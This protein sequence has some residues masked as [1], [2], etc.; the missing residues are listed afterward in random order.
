MA[1]SLDAVAFGGMPEAGI[2]D[3]VEAPGQDVLEESADEFGSGDPAGARPAGLAVP[4][5]EGDG[6]VVDGE[7]APIGD[8][9]AEDVSGEVVED[10][11]LAGR[12]GG[13]MDDPGLVPDLVGEIEAGEALQD[14][15]AEAPAHRRGEGFG[16]DQKGA[17]GGVPDGAVVGE[18]AAGD[19]AVNVGVQVEPLAPGVQD[20]EDADGAADEGGIAGDGDD[21]VAGRVDGRGGQARVKPL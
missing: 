15:G 12:P 17:A 21:G 8:G 14:G 18:A 1:Q 4:V 10:H 6:V 13:D 5:L 11:G 19:Q 3:L 16:G 7:D 2:A 9:D 20:G